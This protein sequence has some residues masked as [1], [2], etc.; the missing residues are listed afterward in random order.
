MAQRNLGL[1][2]KVRLGIGFIHAAHDIH[3]VDRKQFS[4]QSPVLRLCGNITANRGGFYAPRYTEEIRS[5][6]FA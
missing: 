2:H 1:E 5:R 6:A 3:A 4:H